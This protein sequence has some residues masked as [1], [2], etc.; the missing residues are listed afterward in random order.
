MN[1]PTRYAIYH[2]P[3][4][5]PLADFGASWLGR[6]IETG[7]PVARPTVPK[8][9]PFFDEIT[10]KPAHYGFHATLKPPFRLAEGQEPAALAAAVADLAARLPVVELR[11]LSLARLGKFLALVP[12]GDPA[13]LS[14]LAA[15]VVAALDGFRAPPTEAERARRGPGLTARQAAMLERWGYPWVMEEFRFHMTL[16]DALTPAQAEAV[17]GVL[18]PRLARRLPRPFRLAALCLCGTAADG[19]FRLLHRYPLSG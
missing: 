18:T 10:R 15:E 6:D 13:P 16:T 7:L 17:I 3:E 19:R 14:A 9:A 1:D 5:G 2:V 4:P 12:E 8:V 11:G